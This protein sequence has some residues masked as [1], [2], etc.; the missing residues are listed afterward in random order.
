LIV[1]LENLTATARNRSVKTDLQELE[2]TL[3]ELRY[4]ATSTAEHIIEK[5]ARERSEQTS[6]NFHE[7]YAKVLMDNPSLYAK[8]QQERVDAARGTKLESSLA[9]PGTHQHAERKKTGK[10]KGKKS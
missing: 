3:V 7:S 6:E 4:E 9:F 5:L 1:A 2:E 8:Y 10:A